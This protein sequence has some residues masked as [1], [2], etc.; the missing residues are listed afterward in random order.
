MSR[1][2]SGCLNCKRRHRKCDEGRPECLQCIGQGVECEGYQ[3]VLRWGSGIAS[4][5]RFAG[6]LVPVEIEAPPPAKRKKRSKLDEK[7]REGDS[8]V[9]EGSSETSKQLDPIAVAVPSTALTTA[10]G[11]GAAP[12]ETTWPG[13]TEQDRR[14]LEECESSDHLCAL[15]SP[16]DSL[17][18]LV[19]C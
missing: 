11:S 17:T 19:T 13:H 7:T 2:R 16:W 5:G 4:R 6:A 18:G 12:P 10:A 3:T 1:T 15:S 9:R 8:L 14:L